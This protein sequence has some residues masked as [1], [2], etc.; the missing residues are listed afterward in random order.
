MA[1]CLPFFLET[2]YLLLFRGGKR[3]VKVVPFPSS[4]STVTYF[5]LAFKSLAV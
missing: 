1:V 2:A 5:Q 3:M 4:L